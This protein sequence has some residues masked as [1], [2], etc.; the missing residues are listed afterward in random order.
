MEY[1]GISYEMIEYEG[2]EGLTKFKTVDA[3]SLGTPFPNLPYLKDGDFSTAQSNAIIL[4]LAKKAGKYAE[5]FGATDKE[6]VEIAELAGHLKDV[7]STITQLCYNQDFDNVKAT[8]LKENFGPKFEMLYK[9]YQAKGTKFIYADHLVYVDFWLASVLRLLFKMEEGKK[10]EYPGFV[11][12]LENYN[13][14]PQ[15]KEYY[16]S[17]FVERPINNPLRA[18]FF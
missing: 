18:K 16:G 11:K 9:Y 7:Y 6:E 10:E 14:I 5:L 12:F 8:V 2:M 3:P 4:Y 17:K 1:S 13:G 15:I